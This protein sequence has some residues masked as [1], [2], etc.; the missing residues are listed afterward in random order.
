[1]KII[2][3][4]KKEILPIDFITSF[5]SRGW[6]EIGS[7]K[8]DINSIKQ[9]F[10]NT[11]KVEEILQNLLD[12]YLIAIGQMELQLDKKEYLE[13][14]DEK[15]LTEDIDSLAIKKTEPETDIKTSRPKISADPSSLINKQSEIKLTLEDDEKDVE[16][17]E[18]ETENFEFFT[19]FEEP[20]EL[21]EGYSPFK[22]WTKT[23]N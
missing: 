7:L 5:I 21:N 4:A 8:T 16:T 23:H 2:N 12:A 9:V 20:E 14:P 11:T 15:Q 22:E 17:P 18:K 6:N 13:I 1:M 19:D 3:E 10:K